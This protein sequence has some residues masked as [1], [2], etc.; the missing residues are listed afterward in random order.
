MNMSGG[1]THQH[2]KSILRSLAHSSG[3]LLIFVALWG[4]VHVAHAQVTDPVYNDE[5]NTVTLKV[6]DNGQ[7]R[8]ALKSGTLQINSKTKFKQKVFVMK[9]LDARKKIFNKKG[10]VLIGDDLTVSGG[11]TVSGTINGVVLTD[12]QNSVT[13]LQTSMEDLQN[14]IVT[15]SAGPGIAISNGVISLPT[16][17]S[18]GQ[19][20][21]F[22]NSTWACDDDAGTS[23]TAGTGISI[24]SGTIA[25]SLGTTIETGEIT[26][27]TIVS[28]DIND[29]TVKSAD[30]AD[31]T[32]VSGDIFDGTIVSGDIADGTIASAD[33]AD[34]TIVSADIFDG[35]I[36]SGDIADG[37]I[38][39]GDILDGTVATADI[40]N[41]TILTGDISDGTIASADIAASTITDSDIDLTG[42]WTVSGAWTLS[43]NFVNTANPWADN[44]VVD[45]LTISGGTIDNSAI[46]A[47]TASTG[48]FTNI[49]VYNEARLMQARPQIP[50]T[51][52]NV[53]VASSIGATTDPAPAVVSGLNGQPVI[54]F[55]DD[56]ATAL[57]VATCAVGSTF[58]S[59]ITTNTLDGATGCVLTGCSTTGDLGRDPSMVLGTTGLPI[60]S[61]YDVSNSA[62]SIAF[63][64]NAACSSGI[65]TL[66]DG[67]TGCPIG[68]STTN[69]VGRGS[70][71]AISSD[72]TPIIAYVDATATANIKVIKCNDAVDC[73]S[74]TITD[75]T[76]ATSS[77]SVLVTG[78]ALSP[79]DGF[80]VIA[81]VDGSV[82]LG[83]IDCGNAACSSSAT[84]VVQATITV[85]DLSMTIDHSGLPLIAYVE[86]VSSDVRVAQCD[87]DACAV[88]TIT[89]VITA[90]A[91]T[92]VSVTL[93]VDG[94]PLIGFEGTGASSLPQFARCSSINCASGNEINLSP[95][96]SD[97]TD[98][99]A[100]GVNSNGLPIYV[101]NN[102]V[103]ST[104]ELYQAP[105]IYLT[106]GLTLR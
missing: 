24:T 26:N 42:S 17:C 67:T 16:T 52:T 56:S 18:S 53:T 92:F 54:A 51:A 43:G 40:L 13:D 94:F 46:G 68:C 88:P 45:A 103:D 95:N 1:K 70:S 75:V 63:C 9:P 89:N 79:D 5:V 104:V 19:V 59:S 38:A 81:Y 69:D 41:E 99:L 91:A 65:A 60:I 57:K 44:E 8:H 72:G 14:S 10:E 74:P 4:M 55:Y 2:V 100:V 37:T 87:T 61:Y 3:F 98:N 48:N 29:G 84:A 25:A 30:I 90:A 28:E 39:T 64:A 73:D 12:L 21:K 47:T 7:I 33:I 77:A 85:D 36:V 71:I 49:T 27:E 78:M 50:R 86:G 23:Y 20:L 32:I 102:S 6:R 15:Y 62:L 11:L 35:T 76:G 82:D 66:L 34:S 97:K 80:P 106:P 96:S 93:G 58:C 83:I 22:S 31:S 105:N 101:F